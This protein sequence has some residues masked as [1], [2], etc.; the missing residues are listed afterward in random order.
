M[1][2]WEAILR[3]FLYKLSTA[4][5][6]AVD[7]ILAHK[8]RSFLTLLG[9]IIG[10]SSVVLVGAAIDGLG[11]YAEEMTSKAFGSDTF[12]VARIATIGHLDHKQ[13]IEKLRRNKEIREEELAYL[14]ETTGDRILY[15]P[16]RTTQEDVKSGNLAYEGASIIGCAAAMPE[17]RDITLVD[18]RFFTDQEDKNRQTVAVIGDDLKNLFFPGLSPIGRTITIR[19]LDFTVLGVQERLGSAG[20]R[21]QDNQVYLPAGSYTRVF[22]SARNGMAVFAKPRPLSALTLEDALDIT[23]VTL[24]TRFHTKPGA[25]DNFDTITPDAIR[26]FIDDI[27]G[28]IKAVVV[29]VTALSLVVGG[30]VIMNIMLVSVTERTF[31]IGLRKALGARNS[32]IMLQFLIEAVLLAAAGGAIGLVVGEVLAQGASMLFD[33]KLS[34]GLGYILLALGVSTIVGVASGWYPAR[35][36]A[37]LAPIAALRAD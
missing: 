12:L 10:V 27:L 2:T 9:V 6:L 8:L 1:K 35:R 32:D 23:R 18:G 24:R 15:S 4:I 28:L 29:P 31:E 19:G 33:L 26:A 5:R 13:R 37:A 20:G 16:Y 17:I 3:A 21:E 11:L 14:E 34:L 36:A 25:E 30:I 7:S 22:G